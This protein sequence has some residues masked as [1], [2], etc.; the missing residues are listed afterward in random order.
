MVERAYCPVCCEETE[1]IFVRVGDDL[2]CRDH[3]GHPLYDYAG[4][5]GGQKDPA[6]SVS[7]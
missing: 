5:S 4:S 2:V 3:F 6:Q 1:T 7:S